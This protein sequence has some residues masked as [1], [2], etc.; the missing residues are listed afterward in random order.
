MLQQIVTLKSIEKQNK[1]DVTNRNEEEVIRLKTCHF[2]LY[3]EKC[4]ESLF[5]L[6][7]SR[8]MFFAAEH[9]QSSLLSG[10]GNGIQAIRGWRSVDAKYTVSIDNHCVSRYVS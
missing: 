2:R 1:N 5:F 6:F 9:Q 8:I 7:W 3:F 4:H 10:K